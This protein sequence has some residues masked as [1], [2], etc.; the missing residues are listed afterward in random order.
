MCDRTK[1][2]WL[3]V[4]RAACCRL[5]LCCWFC[6]LLGRGTAVPRGCVWGDAVAARL[7]VSS[8]LGVTW[9]PSLCEAGLKYCSGGCP[10]RRALLPS[11]VFLCLKL[12][13]FATFL[14]PASQAASLQRGAGD[15]IETG[16][17]EEL[18]SA[19]RPAVGIIR[20]GRALGVCCPSRAVPCSSS[21]SFE[22]DVVFCRGFS[23][24][25]FRVDCS[26]LAPTD[27][28]GGFLGLGA[29]LPPV[30]R[31]EVER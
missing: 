21:S 13:V 9:L 11:E 20:G 24:C 18:P 29:C 15:K 7:R 28:N 30:G 19:P 10:R 8:C 16:C 2:E 3:S 22:T 12:L 5:A 31:T 23:Q 27:L 4:H 17:G 6:S 14:P 1:Q 25:C 26:R